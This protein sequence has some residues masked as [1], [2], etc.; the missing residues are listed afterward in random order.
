MSVPILIPIKR[1]G[2]VLIHQGVRC[3]PILLYILFSV[4]NQNAGNF[5]EGREFDALLIDPEVEGTPFDIFD[6]DSMEDVILKFLY[7]GKL[8]L[9]DFVTLSFS[10]FPFYFTPVTVNPLQ[11]LLISF[12]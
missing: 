2:D 5:K 9:E 4:L 3:L 6:L 8:E 1:H 12:D 11:Y 7:C 10:A